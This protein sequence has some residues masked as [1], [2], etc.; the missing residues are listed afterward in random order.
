M[1]DIEI[2]GDIGL[3]GGGVIYVDFH[4]HSVTKGFDF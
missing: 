4:L 1:S 3:P 2:N